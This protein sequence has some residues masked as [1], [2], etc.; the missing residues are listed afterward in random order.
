MKKNLKCLYDGTLLSYVFLALTLLSFNPYIY[1]LPFMKALVAA[2]AA[3]GAIVFVYRI[4]H[5]HRY[6]HAPCFGAGAAFMLSYGITALVNTRYGLSESTQGF[7]WLAFQ[8]LILLPRDVTESKSSMLRQLCGIAGFYLA[9]N[10]LAALIGIAMAF[11]GFG[12]VYHVNINTIVPRG[13][14]WGRLWGMYTDPNYGAASVC[15]SFALCLLFLARAR[16]KLVRVLLCL[17]MVVF[18]LYIVFSDSRTGIVALAALTAVYAFC[19]AYVRGGWGKRIFTTGKRILFACVI[20]ILISGIA[21][22]GVL[23]TKKAYN[24]LIDLVYV[25]HENNGKEENPQIDREY[26]DASD[27]SNGRLSLWISGF[28]IFKKAPVF[29]VGFRNFQAAAR[30]LAPDTYLIRNPQKFLYDAYHN[31]LV[32]VT[33]AQGVVGIL[34][35]LALAVCAAVH[36]IRALPQLLRRNSRINRFAA[37]LLSALAAVLAE[38]LFISDLF[39]VNTPTSFMF[40]FLLGILL[41]LS[42][43]LKNAGEMRLDE[44]EQALLEPIRSRRGGDFA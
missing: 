12:E 33:A 4:I 7:L 28:E 9:Y 29:G 39:Y 18:Y 10:A 17:C 11:F 6:M 44:W 43:D 37:A 31:M 34:A 2:T 14:V 16:K 8:L 35:L 13:F 24:G 27:V 21:A 25:P 42:A 41:R 15:V 5:Y 30:V 32:D 26:D 23:G 22:F 38:S 20:A 40:W 36:V 19:R 1:Y 3:L